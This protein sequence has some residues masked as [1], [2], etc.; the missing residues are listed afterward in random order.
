[1]KKVVIIG[2]GLSGLSTA[3]L[4]NQQAKKYQIPVEITLFE[5]DQQPGGKIRSVREDGFLCEWGP[6]GFLDNKPQT[7][8]LC[9]NMG[10][11][12]RLHRS[13]DNARK[14]FIYTGGK[15]HQ[16]PEN[17][18]SF[19]KSKL[20]SWP[21][22][23]RLMAEPFA[24]KAPGGDE[25]LAAFGRRR[26]GTEAM[27][28]L[29]APMASGIFAGD[30]ETMSLQSCFPRI[31]EL[32]RDYGGL[33]KAMLML[34]R[35]KK[36]EREEGKVS[37]SAAGPGGVLTSFKDGIQFLTDALASQLGQQLQTSAAIATISRAGDKWLL[38]TMDGEQLMADLVVLAA[39]AYAAAN[40][41][42]GLDGGLSDT[43][44][45][46]RY[47]S[48]N[49]VCCGYNLSGLGHP[50]DGFGYLIPKEEGR[51]CLGTLWDSSMFESRAAGG[52]VLLRSM[53]GGA[54][55][56]ELYDLSDEEL[57]AGVQADLKHI[58]GIG[59]KPVFSRIIRHKQAIPQYTVG[60][61]E[62]LEAIDGWLQQLPGL[63][64]TGNAFKG[65]GLNDCVAASQTTVKQVIRY[66]GGK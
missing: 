43:L 2:G 21:G 49:V 66:L 62:R 34:A 25:S 9:R 39:P 50:L 44:R 40:M 41:L 32:E 22:K 56:P 60:H 24:A 57:L 6:N 11:S 27:Q 58:M 1:M 18:P 17:G 45:Q 20:L 61:T 51:T 16:L 33:F 8:E 42:Q 5:K 3:W 64:L 14:R 48:L 47:S 30:P 13:N 19:L 53:A 31:A 7:L 12:D 55:R 36:R 29:I 10:I 28:K 59:A 46:I 63:F 54:C 4:L 38:H 15:L 37:S 23:L 65:V 26:L 52:K 35:Q